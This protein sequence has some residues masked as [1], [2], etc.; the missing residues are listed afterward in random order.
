[1]RE[2][3]CRD[4]FDHFVGTTTS[5]SPHAFSEYCG[6]IGA[7]GAVRPPFLIL[8]TCFKRHLW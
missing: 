2:L 1:M 3:K 4:L 8:A 7:A 6:D 5:I